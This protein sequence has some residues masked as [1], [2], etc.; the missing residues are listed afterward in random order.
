MSKD[1]MPMS[2]ITRSFI[3]AKAALMRY[4]GRLNGDVD[5][6]DVVQEAYLRAFQKER[7]REIE[8]PKA[9]LFRAARNIT[10]NIARTNSRRPTDYI[11]DADAVFSAGSSYGP[12]DEI[13]ADELIGLHCVAISLLPRRCREVYVLKKVY[14]YS[15]EEIS[16][17][18]GI[19]ISTVE[20]HLTRG[21]AHC[22]NYLLRKLNTNG[23]S[24]GPQLNSLKLKSPSRD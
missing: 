23:A 15:R 12:C 7:L 22:D 20:G 4:V 16:R 21:Y 1:N 19:S 3:A 5:I 6:E 13:E 10:L 8:N 24:D 18:L 17:K 14:G 2:P 9:Y 11:E